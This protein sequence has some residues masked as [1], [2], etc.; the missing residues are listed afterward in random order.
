MDFDSGN[1]QIDFNAP[2]TVGPSLIDGT[3]VGAS[4]AHDVAI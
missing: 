1:G 4:S 3:H 2:T